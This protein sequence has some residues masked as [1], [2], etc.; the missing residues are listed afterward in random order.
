MSSE[1]DSFIQQQKAKLAQE[2]VDLEQVCTLQIC[3]VMY[4]FFLSVSVHS[5]NSSE[6]WKIVI[7]V[8]LQ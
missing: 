7:S 6:T 4:S 8:F 2:K 5:V 3:P 1:L